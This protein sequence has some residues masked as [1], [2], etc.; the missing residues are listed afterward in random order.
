MIMPR[1]RKESTLQI[2][3]Q[4]HVGEEYNGTVHLIRRAR[5]MSL[6]DND[7]VMRQVF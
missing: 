4:M 7:D 2:C 5:M 6:N 3:Q 1:M